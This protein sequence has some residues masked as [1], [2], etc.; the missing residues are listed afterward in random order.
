MIYFIRTIHGAITF[1]FLSCMVWIY[2][3]ALSNRPNTMAYIAV[4]SI[5]LEG[6]IVLLNHGDC[7]L[8][9]IHRQFGDD[10]AFFELFLPKPVAKK[11]IPFL[12][13][14]SIVGIAL[15]FVK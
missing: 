10:K 7:P 11:A 12:G 3:S 15:L 5:F 9:P 14:I 8:G 1:Y 13:V 2:Y 4:A 6:L